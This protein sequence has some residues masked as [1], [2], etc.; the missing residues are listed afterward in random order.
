MFSFHINFMALFHTNNC[1]IWRHS[2]T[3]CIS[4]PPPVLN[5]SLFYCS[6]DDVI[7][8]EVQRSGESGLIDN[9]WGSSEFESY[10]EQSDSETKQPTRNKVQ[11]YLCMITL[12]LGR[13]YLFVGPVAGGGD[14]SGWIHFAI[15]VGDARA[16]KWH[17]EKR[18]KFFFFSSFSRSLVLSVLFLCWVSPCSCS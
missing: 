2:E 8:E 1:W 16:Q 14:C 5:L 11:M 17:I 10:D 9:G 7:Y 3:K 12:G 4:L 6:E 15:L 13:D 18:G